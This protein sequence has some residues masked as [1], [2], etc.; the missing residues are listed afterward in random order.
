MNDVLALYG[1]RP[2]RKTLLPYGHQT[3]SE[4]DQR[5]VIDVLRSNWLTTGPKVAEFERAF[6]ACVGA[7]EAVAVS[8]GTASLHAAMFAL[9]IG[10]GDE[11]IVPALTFVAT[12]NCVVYQG[13]TPVLV[14]VDPDTL[15][16]D[17]EQARANITPKTKAIIA[18]DYAGQPCEYE[19]LRALAG[20]HG[21]WLVAD[22]CHSLGGSYKGR[23][24][25]SLA[26]LNAFSFHPVKPITTGEGGMVTTDNPGMA[27]RMRRFRNH[28]I[29]SD[30]FQREQGNSWNYEMVDLGMNYRLTDLQCALGLSQLPKLLEWRDKREAIARRYDEAFADWRALRPLA[31]R[32][33]ISHARHLYVI[34]FNLRWLRAGRDEIFRAL[35]AEGIG[36]N[37]H[38]MPVHLHPYY[39]GRFELGAGLCPVAEAAHLEILSLP[40]FPS[41]SDEDVEDVI[42]AVKKVL[43]VYARED[44]M[45]ATAASR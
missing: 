38:Y 11:V 35:R 17:P 37:V 9:G 26:D 24:V 21:L 13:A 42:E 4:E 7:R 20:E 14:D 34:R 6:A 28:G 27:L 18:V 19:K 15:L 32:P 8:S 45:A 16:L 25:G 41:M 1:G 39:R 10:P 36:V 3:V 44:R 12:A 43:E 23:A 29:T 22:A 30:H 33:E 2:V 31:V 5:A 40:L